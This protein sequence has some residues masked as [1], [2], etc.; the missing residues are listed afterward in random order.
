M[1]EQ[2]MSITNI[3]QGP[4]INIFLDIYK[5]SGELIKEYV[6]PPFNISKDSKHELRLVFT[7][8]FEYGCY[9][10]G[11][12][13]MDVYGKHFYEQRL[14]FEY[15]ENSIAYENVTAPKLTNNYLYRMNEI[16]PA[17]D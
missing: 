10:F 4:A 1:F 15:S 9:Y 13:M 8:N 12:L 11:L 2:S 14:R 3:G 16:K 17:N 6:M 7:K 5:D